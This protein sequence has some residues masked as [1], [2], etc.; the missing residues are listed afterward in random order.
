VAVVRLVSDFRAV[1]AQPPAAHAGILSRT[2]CAWMPAMDTKHQLSLLTVV[3]GERE[4]E[5]PRQRNARRSAATDFH[6][7]TDAQY[8]LFSTF[9]GA[10][11]EELSNVLQLYDSIP[12]FSVSARRQALMRNAK[13]G[14]EPFDH[15]FVH[16]EIVNGVRESRTCRIQLHPAMVKRDAGWIHVF[17]SVDEELVSEVLL[18]FFSDANHGEHSSE[19]RESTVYFTLR[20][21]ARELQARG[22]TRSL[23]QIRQSI[24]ILAQTHMRL[25]VG[26][27]KKPVYDA[28]LLAD[29]ARVEARQVEVDPDATWAVRLP[30]LVSEAVNQL[31][32]RQ[33]NFV[34]LLELSSP[35]ARWL[36][37]RL[38][39]SYFNASLAHP[40]SIRFAAV[41]RDSALLDHSRFSSNRSLLEKALDELVH[42]RML[43]SWHIIETM[44]EGR[45]FVD[46]RY[47]LQ[48]HPDFVAEMKAANARSRGV[49]LH[50][51]PPA[52]RG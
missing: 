17:P 24:E 4:E 33:I 5:P 12:K 10:A 14:L 40:Y 27:L 2:F 47:S 21:V 1:D 31:R 22:K 34:K 11:P 43:L 48:A 46:L 23:V 41:Q 51:V 9:L 35:L 19:K 30:V 44:K 13:G 29:V 16:H 25:F 6:P 7:C 49:C 8:Q 3:E 28:N 50:A 39:V 15:S 45:R 20:G 52:P 36:Y 26:D 37:R 38:S 42:A 32:Y 18:K